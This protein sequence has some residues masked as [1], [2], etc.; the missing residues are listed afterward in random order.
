MNNDFIDNNQLIENELQEDPDV[1]DKDEIIDTEDLSF[2]RSVLRKGN[3]RKNVI[4]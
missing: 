3:R 1:S 2:N 4:D